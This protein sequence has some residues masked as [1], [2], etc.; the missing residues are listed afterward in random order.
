VLKLC[1][2][3]SHSELGSSVMASC[4]ALSPTI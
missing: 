4:M 1:Q 3:L 2:E